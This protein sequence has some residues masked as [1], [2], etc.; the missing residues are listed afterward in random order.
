MLITLCYVYMWLRFR[1]SYALLI[2]SCVRRLHRT[3]SFT[4]STQPTQSSRG[5]QETKEDKFYLKVGR[6]LF[7]IEGSQLFEDLNKWNLLLESPGDSDLRKGQ[8]TF[9]TESVSLPSETLSPSSNSSKK[10]H[11]LSEY[12]LLLARYQED[13]SKLLAEASV[14]NFS[15]LGIAFM[16]N[17]LLMDNGSPLH[18]ITSVYLKES[19][20]KA[21][22]TKETN[23]N[24]PESRTDPDLT[25]SVEQE[26]M[27]TAES[28][29]ASDK[30]EEVEV[31]RHLHLSSCHE[32]L[33]LENRTIES[34]RCASEE[35]IPDL[36]DDFSS[37]D[38][39]L[40]Q[41]EEKNHGKL[42]VTGKPPNVLIYCGPETGG[43]FQE[44]K[45]VLLQCFDSSRYVI[46]PLPED[47]VLK[48][49]WTDNCLLL[50]VASDHPVSN[51]IIEQFLS[52]LSK[53]GKILGL[54]SSF[55]F[56]S[57]S[58]TSKCELEGSIQPLVFGRP[59]CDL[60]SLHAVASG[61]V[62]EELS[63]EDS[64]QVTGWGYLNNDNKD[65]ILVHQ[66]FGENG[67]E[68]VLCQVKLEASP[69]SVSEDDTG[70][71]ESL[72]KSNPQRYEVLTQ[73]LISLSLDCELASP[74][75]LTPVYLL[76]AEESL[77]ADVLQ[78]LKTCTDSNGL[79]KSAKMSL[80]V[81]PSL[82]PDI[83]VSPS[84]AP[85]F[86]DPKSFLCEEFSVERYNESLC[87]E[88]L[89]K[90]VLFAE[91][92][93][94]TFNLLEGLMFHEPKE[95]GLIA[96]TAHQTQG[97][98]RGGNAWLSPKGC[99][100]MTLHVSIPLLSVLGQRIAFVQ[101]LMSL[102]V[103][104]SVRSIPGYED[105]DLRVKWPN[106]IYY[107]DM[108]KI[109][110]VLV[111]ST[112]MGNTFHILI[113]CGFNV[114][115]SNPTVCINDLIAQHNKSYRTN[116]EPLRVDTLIARSVTALEGLI[117]TFQSKG[118]DGVLPAYYKYWLHS[119]AKVRLG[120]DDGPLSWIIGVDDSG[121][122]QV[123]QEGKEIV[124]VHPDG[125]SFDMLRNLI[126]PKK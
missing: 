10:V 4:F 90:I 7:L 57:V 16:E 102:A 79:I 52:Y 49:P 40:E 103:V 37:I 117:K 123:L 119:G 118:P 32:C 110:G 14:D 83:D 56:G 77:H 5:I 53:G 84:L 80:K 18:K 116:I 33:E 35:N 87:T 6:K 50:V 31:H 85:L 15:E 22:D 75:A 99:A 69:E 115:N 34:V 39:S 78:W 47:Q 48:A 38:D 126:I 2:R 12:C 112:L 71:F 19:S 17:R 98:G 42:N 62:F 24:T 1:S 122:L 25:Q 61:N 55:T 8:I 82:Q 51:Q 91:V 125:N 26:T 54:S 106:D 30:V 81:Y 11:K 74:P 21:Q 111:N 41:G 60:V 88:K 101:H 63:S 27:G 13:H 86:T 76:T 20:L 64:T 96:I 107:G 109:G 58:V 108:M 44:I 120:G 114:S 68:A 59:N 93:T 105:I 92:T 100:L 70:T 3:S 65:L 97:K 104:E 73:I 124:S 23:L 46:Y 43:R 36:P 45:S 95:M 72:K 121:F 9:I 29:A 28:S 66:T 113:G 67:G 94:T 89:G